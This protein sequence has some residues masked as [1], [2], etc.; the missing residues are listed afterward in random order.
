MSLAHAIFAATS[1]KKNLLS[2]KPATFYLAKLTTS[3]NNNLPNW[4][5]HLSDFFILDIQAW[6]LY[7]E[8]FLEDANIMELVW[9]GN[10][11][12]AKSKMLPFFHIYPIIRQ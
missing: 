7:P 12:R 1:A 5:D 8:F 4:E 3:E 11:D 6:R 9:K 2:W 10:E